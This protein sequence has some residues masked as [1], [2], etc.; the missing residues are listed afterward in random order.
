MVEN[1]KKTIILTGSQ[2]ISNPIIVPMGETRND[3]LNNLLCALTIAGHYLIP[4]V[5]LVFDNYIMRGNRTTKSSASSF[6]AFTSPN[7]YPIGKMNLKIEINWEL[8]KSYK[9]DKPTI[10]HFLNPERKVGVLK[11]TPFGVPVEP[12]TK[13]VVVESYG[14][15]NIP[16]KGP[17]Y[18]WF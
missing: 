14:T 8:I 13:Y 11:L 4:E 10:F 2:G 9:K 17:Y 6:K 5:L 7:Y 3:G 16:I 12:K 1:L 15:G 18:E